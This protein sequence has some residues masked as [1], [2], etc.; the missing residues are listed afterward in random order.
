MKKMLKNKKLY[1]TIIIIC[2]LILVGWIIGI[3]MNQGKEPSGK[4][5]S[6]QD[7]IVHETDENTVE[8]KAE[9]GLKESDSEDGPVLNE[10]NMIDFNGSDAKSDNDESEKN[11]VD[12]SKTDDKQGNDSEDNEDTNATKPSD[13]EQKE[14]DE[15]SDD[16]GSW[17]IFY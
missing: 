3:V 17:G 13:D 10:D 15:N 4:N 9:A 6:E 11:D 8:E 5:D 1:I 2:I 16:T 7:V 14:D 12:D